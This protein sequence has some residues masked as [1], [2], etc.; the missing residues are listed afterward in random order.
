MIR[1]A[2]LL[3]VLLVGLSMTGVTACG[4]VDAGSGAA[5]EFR[6]W[7]ADTEHVDSLD[8]RSNNDLPWSGTLW[9]GVVVEPDATVAQIADVARRATSFESRA[10]TTFTIGYT[11]DDFVARFAVFPGATAAN[12]AMIQLADHVGR[13]TAAT[14]FTAA[15]AAGRS[16]ASVTVTGPD[17][18]LV[19]FD[20][21]RTLLAAK[22]V[23]AGNL[24]TVH[25]EDETF[26]IVADRTTGATG[27]RAAYEVVLAEY[28]VTAAQ[29]T[30]T[31]LDVRVGVDE[32][33]AVEALAR[34]AAPTV[35][36]TVQFGNVTTTGSGDHT[37]AD[38]LLTELTAAGPV[39]SAVLS[40]DSAQIT[41]ADLATLAAMYAAVGDGPQYGGVALTI[42]T[43][44]DRLAVSS[45]GGRPSAYLPVL[46]ALS[47]SLW[48]T[49]LTAATAD[50]NG[51]DVRTTDLTLEQA[52]D[53]GAALAG[54]PVGVEIEVRPGTGIGF[55]L[56]SSAG[57][58]VQD[59]DT[60]GEPTGT[61]GELLV[62]FADGWD[63]TA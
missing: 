24:L 8:M 10:S 35:A 25:D 40:P 47:A 20:E 15:E 6:L 62:A 17:D 23:R 32:T 49:L 60:F 57:L 21:L 42:R 4:S 36:T 9:A 37:A 13:S 2:R 19:V 51:L 44:D 53:L 22:D 61:E 50:A 31:T 46:D 1:R 28:P 11:R 12:L 26:S 33:P 56:V 39:V 52:H 14:E 30:D 16:E 38:S 43:A 41:V 59:L 3:L 7:M 58:V 54:T 5:A 18:F 29:L 55:R 27:P 63:A 45:S 34:R 48:G